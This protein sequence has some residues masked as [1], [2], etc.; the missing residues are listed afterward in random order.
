MF[1][2]VAR[3]SIGNCSPLFEGKISSTTKSKVFSNYTFKEPSGTLKHNI[4]SA[5]VMEVL[6]GILSS[7]VGAIIGGGIGTI[8]NGSHGASAGAS[9]CCAAAVK[10]Y[11]QIAP[12][13]FTVECFRKPAEDFD[14]I[15]DVALPIL[16]YSWIGYS[17]VKSIF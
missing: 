13:S 11:F 17:V 14:K 12:V 15:R 4:I 9:C 1:S 10:G 5:L 7:L 3:S 2:L 16:G 6:K 8:V